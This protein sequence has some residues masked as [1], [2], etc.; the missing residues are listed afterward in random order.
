MKNQKPS[1]KKTIEL[2]KADIHI[3]TNISDGRPTV[4]E[5]VDYVAKKTDLNVIA[6]S[7]HDEIKGG[8]E[9]KKIIKKKGYKLDVIIAEEVTAKEGHIL[10][11]FL[12][13]R[14]KP[15]M[16]SRET[17]EE[18]HR[19]G[20][21]AIAAHPFFASHRGNPKYE[22]TDGVGAVTL[23]KEKFDGI[24][25]LNATPTLNGDNIKADY[26]NQALLHRA[27]TGS[28]D[29]HIKQAIG[30]G[31]TI[32]EGQTAE[33]FRKAF[34]K[35]ETQACRMQWTSSSLISYA[36]YYIPQLCRNIF[37][38]LCLGFSPREPRIVK[39]PKDY[40]ND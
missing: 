10:G 28:S 14:I 1:Q 18:I 33:D 26:I 2:S 12:K 24:E 11:L 39:V 7:D 21:L 34:F 38:S 16:S 20:G 36:L 31:Y 19:Q 17:I 3:H 37:W 8:F 29:A 5:V 30:V 25:T 22:S 27:E 15:G 6:I 40:K 32:F 13:E 4:E 23:I 9:A 35:K